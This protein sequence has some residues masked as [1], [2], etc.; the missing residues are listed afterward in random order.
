[1]DVMAK[2]VELN[3][4]TAHMFEADLDMTPLAMPQRFG[5]TLNPTAGGV[6]GQCFKVHGRFLTVVNL[7]GGRAAKP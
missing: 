4:N 5:K 1:M 7:G 6:E 3:Q 2:T